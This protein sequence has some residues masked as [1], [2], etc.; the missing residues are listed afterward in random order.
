MKYLMAI[1]I[2]VLTPVF[3]YCVTLLI[4]YSQSEFLIGLCLIERLL[5][6]SYFGIVCWVILFLFYTVID[7]FDLYF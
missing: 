4:G 1:L 6:Y 3:G 7:F 2:F 5:V